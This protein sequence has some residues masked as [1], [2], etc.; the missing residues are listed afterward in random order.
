MI[1][2]IAG[3]KH[4][5]EIKMTIYSSRIFYFW[6]EEK[7]VCIQDIGTYGTWYEFDVDTASFTG[8]FSRW[9]NDFIKEDVQLKIKSAY[10]AWLLEKEL[11]F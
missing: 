1:P 10:A 3:K 9:R 2:N 5:F 8:R 6:W 7:Q 4:D 11:G